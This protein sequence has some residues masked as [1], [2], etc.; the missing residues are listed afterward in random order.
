[1]DRGMT[2]L[3]NSSQAFPKNE[4]IKIIRHATRG[5]IENIY[6]DIEQ[7]RNNSTSTKTTQGTG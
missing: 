1:M 2:T 4:V 7:K 5:R 6:R 3:P